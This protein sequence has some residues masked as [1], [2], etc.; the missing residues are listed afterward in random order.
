MSQS[1]KTW[2]VRFDDIP[3]SLAQMKA[4][5]EAA[6]GEPYHAAALL[7]PALCLWSSNKDEAI[8]MI[9]FLRGPAPLSAY[10][11]QF[12]TERLAGNEYIPFSYFDKTDPQS[13][14]VPKPPHIITVFS[15]PSS[16]TEKGY[17]Q[18]WLQSTG[19]DS[20]RPVKLRQK[21]S[22]GQWFLT[23]QMLLAQIRKPSALDP[24]A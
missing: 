9:D 19:A 14:Y 22:T 4:L 8:S 2:Q 3:S 21:P 12:I 20:Q 24:W 15:N 7:I 23:D 1:N 11:R 10:E 6:L 13:G 18:L 17:A 16:F 5:P